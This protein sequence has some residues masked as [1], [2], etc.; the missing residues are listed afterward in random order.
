MDRDSSVRHA[1]PLHAVAVKKGQV[2]QDRGLVEAISRAYSQPKPIAYDYP[3]W[4]AWRKESLAGV[5]QAFAETRALM[6]D[7]YSRRGMTA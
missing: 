5:G 7:D 3:A 6:G 4:S 2:E 1:S